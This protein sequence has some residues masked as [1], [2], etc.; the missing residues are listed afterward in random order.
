LHPRLSEAKWME[1][2][3]TSVLQSSIFP[4]DIGE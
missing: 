4:F 2:K 3:M 1:E